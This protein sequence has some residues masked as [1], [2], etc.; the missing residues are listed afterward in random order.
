VDRAELFFTRTITPIT[1]SESCNG[2]GVESGNT[3]TGGESG[4][5]FL[6]ELCAECESRRFVDF[7]E[8]RSRR[9]ANVRFERNPGLRLAGSDVRTR[10]LV[11]LE[12]ARD[13]NCSL[14]IVFHGTPEGNVAAILQNGLD[15]AKR[16]RGTGEFFAIDPCISF[17]YCRGCKQMLVF[18][19]SFRADG[20]SRGGTLLSSPKTI[21]SFRSE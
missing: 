20:A 8:K 11:A 19:S 16:R 10:F 1:R 9:I 5:A 7:V 21:I 14:A 18:A 2:H 3:S 6:E 17:G 12:R 4:A 13:P 15:P